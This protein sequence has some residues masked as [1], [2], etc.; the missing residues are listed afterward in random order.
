M[1]GT[2]MY[3]LASDYLK[4]M[5]ML[6]S[7]E[8]DERVIL[9]TLEAVQ[10]EIEVKAEN[11]AK[12]IRMLNGRAEDFKAEEERLAARRKAMENGANRLKK[13]LEQCMIALDIRKI[14]TGLFSINIQKNAPSVVIDNPNLVPEEYLIPQE[15]KVDKQAIKDVLK[16]GEELPFAHLEQSESIRIR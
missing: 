1:A 16:K 14:K 7:G 8:D 12:M 4:L 5:D 10:G 13:S 3:D 9:D 15:P 11:Y 2:R 6:E